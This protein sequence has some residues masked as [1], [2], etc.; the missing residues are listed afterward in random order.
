MQNVCTCGYVNRGVS[1][2]LYNGYNQ[3]S[4]GWVNTAVD[5]FVQAAIMIVIHTHTYTNT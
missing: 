3:C 1:G 2:T 4:E 5:V